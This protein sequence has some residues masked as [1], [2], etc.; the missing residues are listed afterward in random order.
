MSFAT[1]NKFALGVLTLAFLLSYLQY[2]LQRVDV[3]RLVPVAVLIA[4]AMLF[5]ASCS[6]RHRRVLFANLT[7]LPTVTLINLV[8]LPPLLSSF[9]RSSSYPAAYGIVMIVTLMAA[10]TLLCGIGLEGLLLAFFYATTAGTVMV[11]VITFSDLLRAFGSVRYFPLNFEPNRIAFFAVTAIPAQLWFARRRSQRSYI[12]L[13]SGLSLLV[14]V[15][16]SSR[17][18]SG[19]LLIGAGFIGL[20]YLARQLRCPSLSISRGS[21]MAGLGMVAALAIIPVVRPAAASGASDYLWTKLAFDSRARGMDSGFTGRA[22]GWATLIGILPKTSWIIGNGY[23]T[24]DEDFDFSVDSGYL[25]SIYELGLFSTAVIL[26]KYLLVAGWLA[27]GF[28]TSN[29]PRRETLA[30]LLFTLMVFL[31]NGFVHRVLFGYGD[32]ASLMALFCL[33]CRRDDI[34]RVMVPRVLTTSLASTG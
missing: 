15:A 21:L 25:A 34:L 33:V 9:Y 27:I 4:G 11:V 19:A 8:C 3:V 6:A 5:A 12:L 30:A 26:L 17:G 10:R 1:T 7:S 29:S 23:R 2:C 31:A 18:S 22:N 24:T 13:A 14:T 20:L 16:A 32:P 28:V